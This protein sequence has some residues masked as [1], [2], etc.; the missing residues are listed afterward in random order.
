M[1]TP[2]TFSAEGGT[3]RFAGPL[4]T[5]RIGPSWDKVLAAAVVIAV[6]L[7]I[8]AAAA[9]VVLWRLLRRITGGGTTADAM[10]AGPGADRR[11]R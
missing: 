3:L 9:I 5:A 7:A 11:S 4:E 10:S 1:D 8:G 2:F 6:M